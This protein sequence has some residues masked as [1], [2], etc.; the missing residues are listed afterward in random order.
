MAASDWPAGA[1]ALGQL[2]TWVLVNLGLG[3][4]VLV[5]TLM[6]RGT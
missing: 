3:G 2:R 1:A 4:V 5:V 6:A